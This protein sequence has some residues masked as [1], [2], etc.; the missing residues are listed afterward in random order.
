MSDRARQGRR[1]KTTCRGPIPAA[2]E[3]QAD[4][5]APVGAVAALAEGAAALHAASKIVAAF[6]SW[7]RPGVAPELC[8]NLARVYVFVSKRLVAAAVKHD[9]AAAREAERVF[10]PVADAFVQAANRVGGQ[11]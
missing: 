9:A 1:A 11:R 8:R 3:G 7:L 4:Y 10:A 2:R 5:Q 6:L